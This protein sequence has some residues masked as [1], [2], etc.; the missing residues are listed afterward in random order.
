MASGFVII[1]TSTVLSSPQVPRAS[2]RRSK[3]TINLKYKER[4][5]NEHNTCLTKLEHRLLYRISSASSGVA[6]AP[7]KCIFVSIK[8][9]KANRVSRQ[10]RIEHPASRCCQPGAQFIVSDAENTRGPGGAGR[11]MA[12]PLW[13]SGGRHLLAAPQAF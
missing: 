13:L 12:D 4:E 1:M 6:E 7:G 2:G 8:P 11:V 3:L 9:P 10:H 5:R